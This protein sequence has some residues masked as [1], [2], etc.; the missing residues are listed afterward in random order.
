MALFLERFVILAYKSFKISLT[1]FREYCLATSTSDSAIGY[2]PSSK[3]YDQQAL[4]EF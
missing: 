4:R 1:F 3:C 2:C